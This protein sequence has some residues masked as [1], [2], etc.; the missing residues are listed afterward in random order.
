MGALYKIHAEMC[1]IFSNATR[2]ELLDLLRQGELSVS[3]LT[4]KTRLS[5]VNVSQHLAIMKAK[6]V[7]T[8]RRKGQNVYYCLT[9]PK[10]IKAFDII[11]EI[12]RERLGGVKNG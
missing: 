1:K 4:T 11:R 3:R 10:I 9:N 12:L 8:S 6:G 5:Q 2:L 7:V